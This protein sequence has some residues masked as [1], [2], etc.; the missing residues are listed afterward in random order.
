MCCRVSREDGFPEEETVSGL[1]LSRRQRESPSEGRT[2][3]GCRPGGASEH[4]Q[5]L[6]NSAS[7]KQGVCSL[8]RDQPT[9]GSWLFCARLL[10]NRVISRSWRELEVTDG[11]LSRMERLLPQLE[12]VLLRQVCGPLPPPQSLLQACLGISS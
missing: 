12:H 5:G 4:S 7:G 9:T 2:S 6:I 10:R 1:C 8:A 11:L 3:G